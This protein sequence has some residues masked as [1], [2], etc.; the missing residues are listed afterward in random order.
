M[1]WFKN[2]GVKQKLFALIGLGIAGIA[3][4][5]VFSYR[6]LNKVKVNGEIYQEIVKDKD[7]LADILPPPA[8]VIESYLSANQIVIEKDS[9]KIEN[10][11]KKIESLKQDFET[12]SAYWD[13]NLTDPSIK[14]SIDKSSQ[15]AKEFFTLVNGE[16][17]TAVRAQNIEKA[18]ELLQGPITSKF[19]EHRKY[20]DDLVKLENDRSKKHEAEAENA[21]S[22]G[23][24]FVIGLG[25]TMMFLLGLLGWF[26]TRDIT[27]LFDNESKSREFKDR[28][29]GVA[30]RVEKLRSLCVTN[31]GKA[32]DAMAIGDLD[33]E[34][35]TGTEYLND[36]T[37]DEIGNLARSVD[38]IITQTKATVAS[39]EAS[40]KTIRDLTIEIATITDDSN[41][42]RFQG[43]YRDLI[44]F[45]ERLKRINKSIESLQNICI[46]NLGGAINAMANG[47]V[48]FQ[49]VTGTKPLEDNREDELGKLSRTFDG[50]LD[51]TKATIGSFRETQS[52]IANVIEEMAEVTSEANNGNIG[53]R[54]DESKY[55]GAYRDMVSGM[56][57][58]LGAVAT[59]IQEASDCLQRM[60]DKDLT[61]KMTGDYKGDFAL[62]KNALNTAAQNLDEGLQQIEVGAEQVTSASA[63]ISQGSQSLAQGASEQAS[64]LE[65]ISSSLQE[66][67]SMTHQNASNSQEARSLSDNAHA[68]TEKGV[69]SMSRL[70]DAIKR[71]KNSADSTAKIVK[72]IEE[73][74]IQTNL[75]ALNAAVEAAR[76]GDAGRGFAVVAEEVRNLAMRSAEAAKETAR[77]I[78]DSVKNSEEGV[79]L[80]G[81]VLANL[82][83][84]NREIE[85]TRLVVSE[86]AAASEQQTQGVEQ[87]NIAVEQINTVTQQNAAN[88]EESASASEEL[89]GQAQEMLSFIGEFNLSSQGRGNKRPSAGGYRPAASFSS[90][91]IKSVSNMN[92]HKKVTVSSG[93]FSKDPR[94]MI[95]FDDADDSILSEF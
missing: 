50:I 55:S 4:Y 24:L 85:K 2:L 39:F 35:I 94:K 42:S 41:V 31:L 6:T 23:N 18:R 5:G 67:S 81:E 69:K 14:S 17:A 53:Y 83:E 28:L 37:P 32:N 58:L 71:I 29:R 22:S 15:P 87:I 75:L 1:D 9:A 63:E 43:S 49:I 27:A 46:T 13:K 48:K 61:A 72:T 52:V 86:I 38:G 60:A 11:F 10:F 12:R 66:I 70:S 3:I 30:E 54:G 19:E 65:E 91:S 76:A 82:E 62:I 79:M 45:K 36:D 77:L 84:I 80:N 7:L 59:P 68:S 73:I 20:I 78:D 90:S 16:F 47:D 26:V 34:V 93:N 64:T 89:S 57:S 21:V 95:P 51:H 25:G 8:Y 92:S 56:N 88:S 40:R 44:E 74:A 33:F